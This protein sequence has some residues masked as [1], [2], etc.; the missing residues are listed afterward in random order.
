MRPATRRLLAVLVAA[1]TI[2]TFT[3]GVAQA[4]EHKYFN[5]SVKRN[6]LKYSCCNVSVTGGKVWTGVV[7]NPVIYTYDIGGRVLFS[8]KGTG[9]IVGM[10]HRVQYN[11][12][13]GCKW[14]HTTNISG[15]ANLQCW[16]RSPY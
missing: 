7:L 3:P 6:Q 11:A 13:S 14:T 2:L 5:G 9:G 16:Y 15:S 4:A 12:F 10:N 1:V 8:A